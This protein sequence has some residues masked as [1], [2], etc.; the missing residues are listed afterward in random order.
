MMFKPSDL[1]E[2][3]ATVQAIREQLQMPL[4]ETLIYI[5]EHTDEFSMMELSHYYRVMA[6]FQ[7]LLAPKEPEQDPMDD[8]N[9]V[10]SRHHY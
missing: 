6:D 7:K 5:K 1:S 9:Y 8:F 10:G 4:L 3:L 2:S